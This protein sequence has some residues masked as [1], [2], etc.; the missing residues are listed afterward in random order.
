VT[1]F[2]GVYW[3]AAIVIGSRLAI[4]AISLTLWIPACLIRMP[5]QKNSVPFMKAWLA[6]CTKAPVLADAL[7]S[8]APSIT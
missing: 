6:M 8:E 7:S 1:L 5:A 2:V 3:N 4:P